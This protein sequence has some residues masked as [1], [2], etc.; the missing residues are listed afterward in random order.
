MSA[1]AVKVQMRVDWG[2]LACCSE[3]GQAEVLSREGEDKQ[4]AGVYGD[5]RGPDM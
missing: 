5:E 2:C 4:A 3:G 1:G